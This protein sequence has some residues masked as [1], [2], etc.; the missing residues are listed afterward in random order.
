[1][2]IQ[3][4]I[5]NAINKGNYGRIDSNKDSKGNYI[6]TTLEDLRG[7]NLR[8]SNL[9]N[10][11]LENA[12]LS[13][14]FLENAN[15]KQANLKNAN[16][17]DAHLEGANL[18]EANLEKANLANVELSNV[19]LF[20][21]NV[22]N[23]K[24]A[25]F[26]LPD[27]VLMA[28]INNKKYTEKFF[29]RK[30]LSN[31]NRWYLKNAV[32]NEIL[33]LQNT[34]F[35]NYDLSNARFKE[36]TNFTNSV[37][38]NC[39]L[40]NAILNDVNLEGVRFFNTS[41]K[42]TQLENSNLKNVIFEENVDLTGANLKN[43]KLNNITIG[44]NIDLTDADLDGITITGTKDME[45]IRKIK[46]A[47][48]KDFTNTEPLQPPVFKVTVYNNPSQIVHGVEKKMEYN[49][50]KTFLDKEVPKDDS[51]YV[52]M[53][54]VNYV[55]EKITEYIRANFDETEKE[56]YI[57][58]LNSM[59]KN[60]EINDTKNTIKIQIG[61]SLDF[62]LNQNK[63]FIDFYIK[64]TIDDSFEAYSNFSVNDHVKAK[65]NSGQYLPAIIKGKS[66]SSYDVLFN[67][68]TRA[69]LTT[70]YIVID[71]KYNNDLKLNNENLSCAAGI[72]LRFMLNNGY[73]AFALCPE[74]C[75]NSNYEKLINIFGLKA[76]INVFVQE[77]S[78]ILEIYKQAF[79]LISKEEVKNNFI[80]YLQNK[81]L[82]LELLNDENQIK[83]NKIADDLDEMGLFTRLEFGGSRKSK[84]SR[85][86]KSKKSRTRK[87]RT[88]KSKKSRTRKSIKS[89][90]SKKSR[91][92]K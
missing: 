55:K 36:K 52:Q 71:D 11:N 49:E 54:I 12:D 29:R 50:Y 56:K 24:N 20:K 38:K 64:A 73:A 66:A 81:Y 31:N 87:S 51:F 27:R 78:K 90:K 70:D 79:R 62:A 92:K 7:A 74:N 4:E 91:N 45:S 41:L 15:L 9:E 82:N 32:F 25:I 65:H 14:I 16:L 17:E 44:Q 34:D 68:N 80:G 63:E 43:T 33:D 85:T 83:I 1:M 48:I 75:S 60:L 61:K 37:F 2:S 10:A 13:N 40:D 69:T 23:V 30:Y 6:D 39:N 57:F 53:N 8:L 89:R 42:G 5:I 86:R 72:A 35:E 21:S 77:W 76:D 22:K 19:N 46:G 3:D 58:R 18:E 84:K 28:K 47:N 59:M 67:D 26:P 88:R